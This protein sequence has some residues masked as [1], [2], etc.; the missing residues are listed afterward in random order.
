MLLEKDNS[1]S[2]HY[3]NVQVLATE[4]YKVSKELPLFGDIFKQKDGRS[5]SL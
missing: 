3:R 4:M 1:V 2:A 5:Y